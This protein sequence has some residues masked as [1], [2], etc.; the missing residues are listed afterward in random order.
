MATNS[1][2]RVQKQKSRESFNWRERGVE[3]RKK[4]DNNRNQ[5]IEKNKGTFSN[6]MEGVAENNFQ[7]WP[8]K[9]QQ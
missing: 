1:L 4:P 2:V 9:F 5:F 6:S 3:V 8:I 7:L